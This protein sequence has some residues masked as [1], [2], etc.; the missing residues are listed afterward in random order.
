VVVFAIQRLALI[1][2][3]A[4]AIVYFCALG[5]RLSADSRLRIG[6]QP[7]TVRDT[8]QPAF[9]GYDRFL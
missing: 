4:F 1:A 6:Q 5:L 2:A 3:V 7:Y 9:G 8:T